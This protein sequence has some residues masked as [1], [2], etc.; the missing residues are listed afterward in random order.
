MP[1]AKYQLEDFLALVND[2]CRNFAVTIH[3]KLL[4]YGYKLKIQSTKTYG[5]HSSYWQP[6]IKSVLGIIAYLLARDGKLMIRIN[7]DNYAKYLDIL[8]RLPENIVRQIAK[9]DT[10][11]KSIDPK[12]C[13]QGCKGYDFHIGGNHYQKCIVNCFLLDVDSESMPFLIELIENESKARC[14]V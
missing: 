9:A 12:K 2:D 10:C 13:W 8:S 1:K 5:L 3:E 14:A 11:L 6:K 7:A 4:R